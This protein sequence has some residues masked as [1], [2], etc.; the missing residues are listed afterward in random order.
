MRD[1]KQPHIRPLEPSGLWAATP[2]TLTADR[3]LDQILGSVRGLPLRYWK[4]RMLFRG[5]PDR[6]ARKWTGRQFPVRRSTGTHPVFSLAKLPGG[7]GWR[8]CPFSSKRPYQQTA[9]RYIQAGCR[10]Q[11]TG[12]VLDRNS[13]LIEHIRINIPR[14]FATTLRFTG[15]VPEACIRD[16]HAP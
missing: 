4:K 13:Y 9:F 15:I 5:L 14:A 8:V 11:P 10:L 12:Y 6:W 3:D 1:S 2:R 16:G 7:I